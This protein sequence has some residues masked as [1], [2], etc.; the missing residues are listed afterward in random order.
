MAL[1]TFDNGRT[2]YV[3]IDDGPLGGSENIMDAV[4]QEQVPVTFFY[5]GKHVLMN[6]AN[7][8]MLLT[9]KENPYVL[10]GNHSYS[11]ANGHYRLFY[12][13][14]DQVVDDM[15]RANAVLGLKT[16]PFYARMPGRDVFRLPQLSQDDPFITKAE[17]AREKIDFDK[18]AAAGFY[19]YGWDLEWAHRATGEPIQSIPKLIQEIKTRFDTNQTAVKDNLILLMHDEMFQTRHNGKANFLALLQALKQEGYRLENVVDYPAAELR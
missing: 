14:P 7:R 6:S 5:V 17:A 15:E 16:P 10:L 18:V 13:N 12:S 1:N 2:I 8:Q 3:T 9:V 4:N 11:H 19:L